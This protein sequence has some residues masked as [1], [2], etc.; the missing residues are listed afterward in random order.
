MAILAY[1]VA[2]ADAVPKAADPSAERATRASVEEAYATMQRV[3][4]AAGYLNPQNPED[5]FDELRLL[6]DRAQP[7]E[8]ESKLLLTAFRKLAR[9]FPDD[10]L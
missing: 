2:I 3:L 7:T 1:E 8:R 5:I 9:G 10:P 6:I 4:L